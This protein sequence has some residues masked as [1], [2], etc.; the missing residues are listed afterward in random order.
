MDARKQTKI[1][2]EKRHQL[3]L[4]NQKKEIEDYVGVGKVINKV[5]I[6]TANLGEL[7]QLP[8][9]GTVLAQ[10]IIDY[11]NSNKF[12]TTKDILNID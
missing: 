6:N 3:E 7:V 5:N 2:N 10:K 4:E 8:H 1:E 12:K 9:I 11:R